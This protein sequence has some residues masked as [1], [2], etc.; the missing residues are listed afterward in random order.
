MINLDILAFGC[1]NGNLGVLKKKDDILI[2]PFNCHKKIK[3]V[4][5]QEIDKGV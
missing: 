1:N 5:Y 4:K 3:K 2:F